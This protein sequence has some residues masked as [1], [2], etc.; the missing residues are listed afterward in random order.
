MI[1]KISIF[2]AMCIVVLTGTMLV[3]A[4][5]TKEFNVFNTRL[6]TN[7]MD[8]TYIEGEI[9]HAKGQK[10]VVKSGLAT[11]AEKVLPD[12]G[13]KARFRIKIPASQIDENKMTPFRVKEMADGKTVA[14]ERVEVEYVP[15]EKQEITT[16]KDKYKLTYPGVDKSIK[17]ESSSG[18]EMI[19]KSSNPDVAKVDEKGNIISVGE[20][21][22][23]I[24][25]KQ[26]GS[27]EYDEAESTVKVS[28]EAIDAYSVI[29]HSRGEEDQTSK[30]II[31]EDEETSLHENTFENG[32]EEFLGW[33]RTEDGLVEFTDT[34]QVKDLAE[35]GEDTD[36]YAVWTGDGAR[37]AVAWACQIA[38]DNSFSYGKKP[39]TSK[40]GCYF[41]GTNQR[42][43]PRGY[44]KTYVCLTFVEAAY[45]H[46]AKDPEL[47]AEC[48]AGKRCISANNSNFSK[49]SCW[50]KVGLA[51]N[52]SINDLKPGDVIVHYTA[53]G[54]TNGHVSMYAGNNRIVDAEG[55]RD[56][57]GPNSIAVRENYGERMLRGA[58]RFNGN[59]Y[60]MR[61]C[62]PNAED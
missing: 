6:V 27:S 26:I 16:A 41:C 23:E 62:G 1:R 54:Y 24:S 37:A 58:A 61:Y 21:E 8:A 10:V 13:A 12:T 28:V 43:K 5:D 56:C 45:A 29:F 11:V 51:K 31:M 39:Q 32:E 22:A 36:L 50:T 38:N 14:T 49:Y 52:L 20:G 25:V 35:K 2:L 7:D 18:E 46:G 42:N 15:R 60:V 44:E 19:Y 53:S 17:A 9:A 47:L 57:W 55:I 40:V 3:T 59:S 4:Q 48:Q 33:A 34:A 30:Q